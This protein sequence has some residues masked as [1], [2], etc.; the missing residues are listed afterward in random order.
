M[1]IVHFISFLSYLFQHLR[2]KVFRLDRTGPIVLDDQAPPAKE[3]T[4]ACM[5]AYEL[6]P[7]VRAEMIKLLQPRKFA[8]HARV[9]LKIVHEIYENPEPA[10]TSKLSSK[11]S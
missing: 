1:K 10:T 4:Q 7:E 2:I 3:T 5:L 11:A 9:R 6:G 8:K